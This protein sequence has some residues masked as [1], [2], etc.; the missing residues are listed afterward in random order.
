MRKD[1]ILRGL[2][3]VEFLQLDREDIDQA[4]GENEEEWWKTSALICGFEAIKPFS[5]MLTAVLRVCGRV[6]SGHRI[7]DSD[8]LC[9]EREVLITNSVDITYDMS[10]ED[11]AFD[12]GRESTS[13]LS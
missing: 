3:A 1:G 12:E 7:R 4:H 6:E 5:L 2:P 11:N 8:D 10:S 13:Q 9:I